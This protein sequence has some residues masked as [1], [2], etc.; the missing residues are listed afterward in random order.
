MVN[1][2]TT[3][4][5]NNNLIKVQLNYTATVSAS[6]MSSKRPVCIEVSERYYIVFVYL[7]RHSYSYVLY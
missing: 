2:E 1:L 6:E 4:N 5:Y 7:G 3:V